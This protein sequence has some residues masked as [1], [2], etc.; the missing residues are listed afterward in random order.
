MFAIAVHGHEFLA[1]QRKE[2]VLHAALD[3]FRPG[4]V[5]LNIDHF[6]VFEQRCIELDRFFGFAALF[7]NEHQKG[8]EFLHGLSP[9]IRYSDSM[10]NRLWIGWHPISARRPNC[11]IALP[12]T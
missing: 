8:G 6:R 1:I 5:A 12:T 3:F 7:A 11:P 2:K 4:T 9:L 10:A